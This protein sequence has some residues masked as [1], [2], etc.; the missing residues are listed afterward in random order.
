MIKSSRITKEITNIITTNKTK[1]IHWDHGFADNAE[2]GVGKNC[3]ARDGFTAVA[4]EA[5]DDQST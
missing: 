3:G 1:M 5:K 4:R 2:Q